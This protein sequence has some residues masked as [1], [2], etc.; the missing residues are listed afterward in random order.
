MAQR[1]ATGYDHAWHALSE[2]TDGQEKSGLAAY[3]ILVVAIV[4]ILALL[5]R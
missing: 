4:S 3:L 2:L 1:I 5:I